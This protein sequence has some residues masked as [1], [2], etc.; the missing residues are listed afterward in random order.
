M[1]PPP[2]TFRRSLLDSGGVVGTSRLD[3]LGPR[4][5]GLVILVA[6]VGGRAVATLVL[7]DVDHHAGGGGRGSVE[8]VLVPWESHKEG[9]VQSQK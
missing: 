5:A 6:V 7:A 1:S 4:L 9:E 8:L 3:D 2:R